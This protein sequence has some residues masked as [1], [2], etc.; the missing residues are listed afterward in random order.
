MALT[1]FL[2]V[3]L[4]IP[5]S[6]GQFQD[7]IGGVIIALTLY[8]LAELIRKSVIFDLV[9]LAEVDSIAEIFDSKTKMFSFLIRKSV[10]VMLPIAYVLLSPSVNLSDLGLVPGLP[11]LIWLIPM[12]LLVPFSLLMFYDA[13]G[14]GISLKEYLKSFTMALFA[15]GLPEDLLIIGLIGGRVFNL[16][17]EF[18]TPVPARILT[19]VVVDSLFCLSHIPAVHRAKKLYS[20]YMTKSDSM[21]YTRM[22]L[23]MFIAALPGWLFYF[24]TSHIYFSVWWH[25]LADIAVF[26]PKRKNNIDEKRVTV[27]SN[28]A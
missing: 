6:F 16:I 21:S 24:L 25:S 18:V 11:S 14:M 8:F 27:A 3:L 12:G 23:Q 19:V 28:G 2:L 17:S 9:G 1:L 26:L 4:F 7:P 20:Q 22:F 15:A 13:K 10:W 5:G